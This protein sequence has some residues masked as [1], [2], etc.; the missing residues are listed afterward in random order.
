MAPNQAADAAPAPALSAT[1]FAT[2]VPC[3]GR[4]IAFILLTCEMMQKFGRGMTQHILSCTVACAEQSLLH[5][6]GLYESHETSRRPWA[7]AAW[8]VMLR[9]RLCLFNILGIQY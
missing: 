7:V 8:L 9:H 4:P 1:L 2:A 6:N 3:Q 5:V